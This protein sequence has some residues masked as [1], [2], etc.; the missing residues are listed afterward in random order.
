MKAQR[1]SSKSG[2]KASSGLTV[3]IPFRQDMVINVHILRAIKIARC[4]KLVTEVGTD[5]QDHSG[6]GG[7][8]M[9]DYSGIGDVWNSDG[10]IKMEVFFV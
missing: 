4:R 10:N 5:L 9:A 6:Q 1:Y 8:E 3:S 7:T 2:K